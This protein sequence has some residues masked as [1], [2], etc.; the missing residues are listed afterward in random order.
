MELITVI[1]LTALVTAILASVLTYLLIRQ[2]SPDT[3]IITVERSRPS[4]GTDVYPQGQGKTILSRLLVKDHGG[5]QR[6]YAINKEVIC[7]GREVSNDIVLDEATVS[8]FHARIQRLM[9]G[10]EVSF[11][12]TDLDSKT[13]TFVNDKKL[14]DSYSLKD[15][16]LVSI[17]KTQMM[18]VHRKF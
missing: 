9:K 15:G 12:L 2:K 13:G 16:D 14:V 18:F 6:D 17:G 8:R 3:Q 7:I 10:E 11:I 4:E 5:F 1:L